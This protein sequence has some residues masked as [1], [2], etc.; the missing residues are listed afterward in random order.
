MPVSILRWY[1]SVVPRRAAASC[2]ALP[3]D[4]VEMVGVSLYSKM[5]VTSET[6]SAPNTR[7]SQR[8]PARRRTIASSMSAHASIVAPARSSA[9]ATG[10]E[11]WP[12]ALALTTA[13]MPGA[14]GFSVRG[15][16]LQEVADRAEV[17]GD[18]VQVHVGDGRAD[19]A[20]L[21]SRR[22][23]CAMASE[24]DVERRSNRIM[25]RSAWRPV[26]ARALRE[27]VTVLR[28]LCLWLSPAGTTCSGSA[29]ARAGR[30]GSCC[31][32]GRCAAWR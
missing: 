29:C 24:V 27:P 16:G 26:N 17:V 12:Y 8:T 19:H 22:K 23:L 15:S 7:I 9:S 5:P 2:R 14:F 13:T 1:L 18:G 25:R 32:W 6:P 30:R 20:R 4:G 3:A 11:P 10:P 31:R 21:V 28:D